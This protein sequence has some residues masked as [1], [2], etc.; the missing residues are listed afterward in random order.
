MRIPR[1]TKK[2]NDLQR[3]YENAANKPNTFYAEEFLK[4]NGSVKVGNRKETISN[5]IVSWMERDNPLLKVNQ[6]TTED[7]YIVNHSGNPTTDTVNSNRYEELIAMELFKRTNYSNSDIDY[8]V[9]YQVPIERVKGEKISGVGKIDLVAVSHSKKQ[10]Y[11]MELKRHSN[12]E[13]LIRCA[14]ESYTYYKQID[15]AKLAKEIANSI[16]LKKDMEEN[17]DNRKAEMVAEYEVVPS[18]L[19]FENQRQHSQ[20]GSEYFDKVKNLMNKLKISIFVIEVPNGYEDKNHAVY[21]P[22]CKIKDVT[23]V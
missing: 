11:L 16:K 13:S 23:N 19:V 18:V 9:E 3:E 1:V 21:I 10:I 7:V 2:L 15:I 22:Q 20:Y 6:I 14:A 12:K 17:C 5:L 8:V 4:N